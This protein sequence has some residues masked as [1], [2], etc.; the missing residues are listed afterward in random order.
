MAR[1]E[2]AEKRSLEKMICM[3]C[4]ARNPKRADKCRKCGYSKLRPKAK[5]KRAA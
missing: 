4:N 3:R 2:A 1:F 5:E